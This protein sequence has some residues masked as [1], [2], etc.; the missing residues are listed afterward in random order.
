MGTYLPDARLIRI[1]PALDHE[2]VPEFY[3]A[4][5][6]FHEMLHQIVPAVRK[7]GRT[8]YHPPEFR[9]REREYQRRD[10]A[11]AWEKA[12]FGLLLGSRPG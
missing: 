2:A 3:V 7:G 11:V 1:H 12:N 10:D 5:V 9:R 4:W 6:V 8:Y